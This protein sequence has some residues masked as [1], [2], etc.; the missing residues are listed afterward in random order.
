MRNTCFFRGITP[1]VYLFVGDSTPAIPT[2]R[3]PDDP[4]CGF[5]GGVPSLPNVAMNGS[6]WKICTNSYCNGP[7]IASGQL[8]KAWGIG[9]WHRLSLM[10][11]GDNATISMDGKH[12]WTGP[13]TAAQAA[14]EQLSVADTAATPPSCA[15]NMTILPHGSMLVGYD[16]R[17]TQLQ[18]DPSD[19]IHCI[20]ACCAD[21]K[22]A[23]WAVAK[24]A[25]TIT[26]VRTITT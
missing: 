1:G 8:T 20:Q 15:A 7:P 24:S 4:S 21:S 14:P 5:Q 10:T 9:E 11:V 2:T 22:C 13:M 17:Q 18:S 19:V 12:I 25:G 23:A 3:N 26:L 16:Y 6:Q